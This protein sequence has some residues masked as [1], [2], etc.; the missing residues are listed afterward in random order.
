[1]KTNLT[2]LLLL[3]LTSGAFAQGLL[4]PPPTGGNATGV[5]GPLGPSGEPMPTMKTLHQME[6]R[7][8]LLNGPWGVPMFVDISDPAAHY[9]INKPGSY[10]LSDDLA[11]IKGAG[12]IIAVDNVTL[13]MRGFTL[14][15]D[16]GASAAT[17]GI[18][19]AS[20]VTGVKIFNG[21]FAGLDHGISTTA[22]NPG[23][24]RVDLE[25][26]RFNS[27]TGTAVS[28]QST[29]MPAAN[30]T[31]VHLRQCQAEGCGS[32]TPG[33]AVIQ[34]EATVLLESCTIMDS[35]AATNGIFVGAGSR[36]RDCSVV[37]SSGAGAAIALN[38]SSSVE[39]C[40]VR[41]WT[42]ASG[43]QGTDPVISRSTVRALVVSA[44]SADSAAFSL[45]GG[46]IENSTAEACE[47]AW[48][49]RLEGAAARDCTAQGISPLA[50]ATSGWGGFSLS[51][52]ASATGCISNGHASAS[53]QDVSENARGSGF[54]VEGDATTPSGCRVQ[55][56][57]ALGLAG[58]GIFSKGRGTLMQGNV[59]SGCRVG[60][61]LGDGGHQIVRENQIT[62]SETAVHLRCAF[63]IIVKNMLRA[64]SVRVWDS[65]HQNHIGKVE[66]P[67]TT[68]FMLGSAVGQGFAAADPWANIID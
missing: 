62:D 56:C 67:T 8:D 43:I 5:A 30:K 9:I 25:S 27:C 35:T 58:S 63:N 23:D 50:G 48:G 60:I 51:S 59:I 40:T 66:Q 38:A 53:V 47:C 7:H 55:D 57:H 34:L 2:T 39:G 3:T 42:G 61:A 41:N 26:L 49:F 18:R 21:T 1:M 45:S 37:R 10:Y 65:T 28:I 46:S 54:H 17:T 11:V 14:Q 19:L 44:W 22:L 4:T 64:S 36:L 20:G 24:V 29:A 12:I 52:G 6:P 32:G 68:G 31:L 13:D 15:R 33:T 16:T